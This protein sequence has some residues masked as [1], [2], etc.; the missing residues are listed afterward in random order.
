M[1]ETF[2]TQKKW[3]KEEAAYKPFETVQCTPASC[4]MDCA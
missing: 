1:K 4:K 2:L 3:E